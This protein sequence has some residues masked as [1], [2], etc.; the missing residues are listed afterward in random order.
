M[1]DFVFIT[2]V[3]LIDFYVGYFNYTSWKKIKLQQRIRGQGNLLSLYR[4]NSAFY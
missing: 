1:R 2:V 3:I 4:M